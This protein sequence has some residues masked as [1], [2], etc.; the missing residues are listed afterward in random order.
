[1]LKLRGKLIEKDIERNS[2][3]KRAAENIIIFV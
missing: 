1:M 2:I 3:F